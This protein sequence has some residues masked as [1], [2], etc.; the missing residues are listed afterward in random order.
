[1][2][3]ALHARSPVLLVGDIDRGGV[4]ASL[5]RARGAVH[6][7]GARPRR[8]VRHQQVP[9]RREPAGLRH[10]DPQEAHRRP[11]ARRRAHARGM[12]RRTRRTR[13]RSTTGGAGRSRTR[14]CASPSSACRTSP[15]RRRGRPGRGAGRGRA[16]RELS[17]RAGGRR[18]D[19]AAGHQEHDRRPRLAA[20]SAGSRTRCRRRPPPGRRWS[21][22]A[23][24]TRCSAAASSI[25]SAS[26]PP[27]AAVEG[28]G[29]LDVET[30]FAADK[31]TVR[32]EGELLGAA[33]G[34]SAAGEAPGAGP[35][36]PAGTPV[37]GYEIHMGRTEL[38]PGAAPL[39][40]LRGAGEAEHLDGAAAGTVCGT[41][42]HGLFDHPEA[43]RRVP[44]RLARGAR[45]RSP[46]G[47][48]IPGRRP[49]PPRRP[50]RGASRHGRA[51]R[52]HLGL[53][54]VARP[55]ATPGSDAPS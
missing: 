14:R 44:E 36:G 47:F 23:A 51:R 4:F 1:M 28:L 16:L 33:A 12:E 20:A 40:R 10:R 35:L 9:R 25:P 2:R 52:D 17:R 7:G 18:G 48:S 13:S 11:D 45:P 43:A 6:P 55:G 39:L 34:T 42:L 50:R 29:L 49:R 37:R 30:T 21:A 54:R 5:A 15:T 41:Y 22:S 31:R 32:A 46:S 53:S 38:G 24:A 3:M 26:S 8:G 19:R 27:S